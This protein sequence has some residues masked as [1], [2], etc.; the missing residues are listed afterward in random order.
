MDPMGYVLLTLWS[1]TLPI[2]FD[3][4]F[5]LEH[6]DLLR[7]RANRTNQWNIAYYGCVSE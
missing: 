3:E 4:N 2:H 5:L 7:R 1:G 6:G